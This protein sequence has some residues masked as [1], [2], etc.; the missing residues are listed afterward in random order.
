MVL[1]EPQSCGVS[2]AFKP[3]QLAVRKQH[4]GRE[5]WLSLPAWQACSVLQQAIWD[6]SISCIITYNGGA[7][8]QISPSGCGFAR[9]SVQQQYEPGAHSPL[10][11]Q[12]AVLPP[13]LQ[14]DVLLAPV[15]LC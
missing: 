11:P 1:E 3:A 15:W 10:Q 5:A 2:L 8:G 14:G 13:A 12:A 6:H 7:A 9:Q 4:A